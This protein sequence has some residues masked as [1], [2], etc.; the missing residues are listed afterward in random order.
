M[1][2]A[3]KLLRALLQPLSSCSWLHKQTAK[4][5]YNRTLLQ[6]L[7]SLSEGTS[8]RFRVPEFDLGLHMCFECETFATNKPQIRAKQ[9]LT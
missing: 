8:D 5:C 6:K 3:A 1:P 7:S 2:S 9:G 4:H